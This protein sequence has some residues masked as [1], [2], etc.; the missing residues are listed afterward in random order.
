MKDATKKLLRIM[1]FNVECGE[2]IANNWYILYNDIMACFGKDDMDF[3]LSQLDEISRYALLDW[4]EH[5]DPIIKYFEEE[6]Q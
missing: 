6:I 4:Y 1:I 5:N 2:Y 3:R